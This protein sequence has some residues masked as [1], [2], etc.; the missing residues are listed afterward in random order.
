MKKIQKD[1]E[2]FRNSEI[3]QSQLRSLYGGA[4]SKT[5]DES[6]TCSQLPWGSDDQKDCDTDPE[7]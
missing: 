4:S 7:H 2:A 5:N 1:L 6:I 3:K